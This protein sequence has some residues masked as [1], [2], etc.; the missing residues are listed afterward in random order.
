MLQW[1]EEMVL[2]CFQRPARQKAAPQQVGLDRR[3]ARHTYHL[4]LLPSLPRASGTTNIGG[5][6]YNS[7][8]EIQ[9]NQVKGNN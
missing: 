6:S 3:G 5:P 9:T 8:W 2:G 4:W 7:L 1:A